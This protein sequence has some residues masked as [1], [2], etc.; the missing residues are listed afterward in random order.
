ME[1]VC[2]GH[3]PN[4]DDFV[5]LKGVAENLYL[6]AVAWSVCVGNLIYRTVCF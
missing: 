1:A 6:K 5:L 3:L 4:M 2:R